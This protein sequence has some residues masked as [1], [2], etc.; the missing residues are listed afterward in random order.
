MA[1]QT[2]DVAVIALR[3]DKGS[4]KVAL[5]V[6][7]DSDPANGLADD[8]VQLG[9]AVSV[10]GGSN[11]DYTGV[12]NFDFVDSTNMKG[13]HEFNIPQ[14]ATNGKMICIRFST[15]TGSAKISPETVFV[16]T[17][18]DWFA[19]MMGATFDSSKDSLEMIRQSQ[20]DALVA[21]SRN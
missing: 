1:F 13:V 17:A 6:S 15:S 16:Y 8:R 7:A 14:A 2:N 20:D 5:F 19:D 9:A 18:P 3:K 21:I 4:Q 12:A 11:T 10:D